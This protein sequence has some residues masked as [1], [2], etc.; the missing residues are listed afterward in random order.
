MKIKFAPDIS[1]KNRKQR[2]LPFDQI[3]G[4]EWRDAIF[5]EDDTDYCPERRFVAVGC[6]NNRLH[7]IC[8]MPIPGGV[9]IISLR[10]TNDREAKRHGKPLAFD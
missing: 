7:V 4:F 9:W 6:L 8:F 3:V 2:D 5:F 1:E 10:K